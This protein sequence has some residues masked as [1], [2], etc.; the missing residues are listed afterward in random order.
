MKLTSNPMD[1]IDLEIGFH[2]PQMDEET[3][4]QLEG[5]FWHAANWI[6]QKFSL[7][8]L[9]LSI[10]VIDDPT[11][12]RINREH[13]QHDWP[14]DVISFEFS[15]AP[16]ASGEILA[17]WDTAGRLAVTAGWSACD[18]LLLYI[19]HGMLHIVG[20]DD[21]DST[22]RSQMRQLEWEYLKHANIPGCESYLQRFDDVSY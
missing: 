20:I 19:V 6:F 14:T 18:E 3:Q 2:L 10:S 12:H 9:E 11:I 17:S 16:A 4:R 13:L 15:P 1:R 7:T 5:R 22:S 21:L 8:S